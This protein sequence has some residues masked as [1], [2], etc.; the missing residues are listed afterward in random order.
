MALRSTTPLPPS[1]ALAMS[2]GREEANFKQKIETLVR[3]FRRRAGG[4]APAAYVGAVEDTVLEHTARKY[5]LD[6]LLEGLGWDISSFDH[7][8][9]EEARVKDNTTVF[10]DY[11]GVHPESRAPVLIFEAKAWE[12]PLVTASAVTIAK[13]GAKAKPSHIELISIALK[14]CKENEDE[15]QCPVSQEWREWLMKLIQ[16]VTAVKKQ[17]GHEVKR[18]AISSGQWIVVF[19]DPRDAFLDKGAANTDAIFLFRI[20]EYVGRSDDIYQCL[21][22]RHLLG[23]PPPYVRPEHIAAYLSTSVARKLF[24]GVW[25]HQ[26]TTGSIFDVHPQILIYPAILVQRADEEFVTIVDSGLGHDQFRQ[27]ALKS[28]V[29]LKAFARGQSGYSPPSEPYCL[30]CLILLRSPNFLVSFAHLPGA[31]G[32]RWFSHPMTGTVTS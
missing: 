1:G 12:K 23:A 5:F 32:L 19:D 30:A 6:K 24:R 9:A 10:M 8:I 29:I 15:A 31:A 25:V 16:Y 11:V 7:D 28:E 22:R 21:A 13:L 2:A 20:E 14:H 27:R 4:D 26:S 17:S 3:E 18:V